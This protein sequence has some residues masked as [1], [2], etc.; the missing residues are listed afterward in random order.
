MPL[1][2]SPSHRALRF[3]RS[4]PSCPATVRFGFAEAIHHSPA[5]VRFDFA[6]AIP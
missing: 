2:S 6:E 5:T 1:S 4:H 3:C